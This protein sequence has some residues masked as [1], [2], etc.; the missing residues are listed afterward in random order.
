MAKRLHAREIKFIIREMGFIGY[1]DRLAP[2]QLKRGYLVDC[3]NALCKSGEIVKRNGY[4]IIGN[5]LGTANCQGIKGVEFANGTKE[6][7]GVFNGL[8]YKWTGSGNWSA[9]T[10]TYTLSTTADV[11][12]VVANNNAYFFDGTNTVPKY[13]GTTM[14]TVAAIPLGSM[15]KWFHNQMHIAGVSGSPSNLRSSDVGDPETYTGGASS[16][17]NVNPNDG[18]VIT[19]LGIL[20][21]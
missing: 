5:D 7:I 20:K 4:T 17:L 19:G 18:D 15:A 11:D 12:I 10:G 21:D 16:N 13:N 9:L 8:T 3:L 1:N 14:S 2:E 6:V